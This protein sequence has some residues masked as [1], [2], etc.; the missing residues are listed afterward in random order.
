MKRFG[1]NFK[2]KLSKTIKDI[3]N[4]SLVEIVAVVKAKS[5]DY[6]DVSLR[7][8]FAGMA[9]LFSWLMFSDFE[10]NVYYIYFIT[11]ISFVVF[12]FL[13]ELIK[14]FQ[15]LFI[16]KKRMKRNVEIY[17]RALF[18]KGG[19]RFTKDKIGVLF[20]VSLFEKQVYIIPDRGALTALPDDDWQ[21]IRNN[22][23]TIFKSNDISDAFIAELQKCK[24]IFANY[25]PPVENDINELP[26]DLDLTL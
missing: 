25:I 23:Q 7:I 9:L 12:Y 8:A 10:I 2:S 11:I 26:D 3:E 16:S 18:Q 20:F 13:S 5:A 19:V 22:F 4:N 14:P 6:K 17:A 21:T 1:E 24:S 15:V